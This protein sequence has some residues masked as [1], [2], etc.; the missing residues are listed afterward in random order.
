M[1]IALDYDGTYTS[2]AVLWDSFIRLAMSR[3]HEIVI[4]TMRYPK[5]KIESNL[6]IIYTSRSA[7]KL[8]CDEND[9][10]FDIWIDDNPE[11]LFTNG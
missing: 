7:K 6:E 4:V 9:L 1:K 11:W 3:G 5:E 8:Y 2:D 10:Y